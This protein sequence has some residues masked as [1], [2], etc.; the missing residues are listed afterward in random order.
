MNKVVALVLF[1]CYLS[2]C[3]MT[4]V[5][6]VPMRVTGS[7]ISVVPVIGDGVEDVIGQSADLIDAIPI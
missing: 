3:V 2:G 7:V 5:L 6:T 1:A 4:K